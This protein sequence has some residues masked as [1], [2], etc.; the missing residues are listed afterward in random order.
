M[1]FPKAF[2]GFIIVFS[3]PVFQISSPFPSRLLCGKMSDAFHPPCSVV[4][5]PHGSVIQTEGYV[6]KHHSITSLKSV[7]SLEVSM[8]EPTYTNQLTSCIISL[9][10]T[11][12]SIRATSVLS[13]MHGGM[14][15]C[16]MTLDT[17]KDVVVLWRSARELRTLCTLMKTQVRIPVHMSRCVCTMVVGGVTLMAIKV[18]YE[19]LSSLI[20]NGC[21]ITMPHLSPSVRV[22]ID[23]GLSSLLTVRYKL[24]DGGRPILHDVVFDFPHS[25]EM[26]SEGSYRCNPRGLEQ[27]NVTYLNDSIVWGCEERDQQ[28]CE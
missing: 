9:S 20:P 23:V 21:P 10:T 17:G 1:P 11:A 16:V 6:V 2:S 27:D 26:Y 4:S 7:G 19:Q 12:D 28:F 3:S 15:G 8:Y 18:F 25:H 14:F 13:T 5:C 24:T 22:E